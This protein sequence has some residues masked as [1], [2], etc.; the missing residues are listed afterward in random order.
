MS[1]ELFNMLGGQAAGGNLGA[2]LQQFQ[3]FKQTFTGDPKAQVQALLNSGRMTQEQYNQLAAQ[4]QQL[5]K[6]IK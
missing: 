5:M 3:H 4:A 2:L 6:M 1:N